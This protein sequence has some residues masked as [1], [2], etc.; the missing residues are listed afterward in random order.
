MKHHESE[1]SSLFEL[2]EDYHMIDEAQNLIL[3]GRFANHEAGVADALNSLLKTS[4]GNQLSEENLIS[5][6]LAEGRQGCDDESCTTLPGWPGG[7]PKLGG[8]ASNYWP[9][10][11]PTITNTTTEPHDSS[12]VWKTERRVEDGVQVDYPHSLEKRY[13]PRPLSDVDEISEIESPSCSESPKRSTSFPEVDRKDLYRHKRRVSIKVA[14]FVGW[15]RASKR[16][17]S[18]VQCEEPPAHA[19]THVEL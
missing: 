12:A 9:K 13:F 5:S 18:K 4:P 8:I 7:N 14:G 6:T 19:A 2:K 16:G 11:E 15:K 1:Q 3:P 10:D 17:E